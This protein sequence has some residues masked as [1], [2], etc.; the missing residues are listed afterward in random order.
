M[1][2]DD[3][4]LELLLDAEEGSSDGGQVTEHVEDCVRCQAR[5]LH[6]AADTEEWSETKHWLA[7]DSVENA[8]SEDV[9][10]DHN[11]R[12]WQRGRSAKAMAW[13]D[14]MAKSLL[15][16]PSHPEMLGRIGRYDVERLIGSGGMGLVFKAYDI[17][18]NRPV[19]VKL[20]APYLAEN[21]SARSRFAREARAAA[22]VVDE[23][24]VAIHNVESGEDPQQ[25]PFLVMK[26][27]AGGSL[28]QRLDRDG[29]LDV[30]EVL[31]IGMQTAKGLAA[32]HA[33]GLIHRD[34]KP[35]NILLDEGVD[36]ALLTDFGLARA[37]NDACLT[38]SGFHPGTPHYM[39]PE[40]VRGEAIDGRSD[41]FG[42][43]CVLYAMC[44]GHPPFRA[45]TSYAV[46]RRITDDTARRIR[47]LNP[48][49][50]LWLEQIVMK[51]L[52]KSRE[53]RFDS[54]E[55]VAELLEGC[56][57]HVQHPT[58]APLPESVEQ[59][60]QGRSKTQSD[61]SGRKWLRQ[62][63]ILGFAAFAMIFAGV[64]IVLET[65][66]GTLTIES[67]AD[68][69]PIRIMQ[70]GDVVKEFTVTKG[71]ESVR[72][73]AGQYVI[74]IDGQFAD[75]TVSDH[76][77][78]LRR[79][80]TQVVTLRRTQ[81]SNSE[82][83]LP[84]PL[85]RFRF[86]SELRGEWRISNATSDEHISQSYVDRIAVIQADTL[87]LSTSKAS[88]TY[89]LSFV[90]L[91]D[92]SVA[93]DL[94]VLLPGSKLDSNLTFHCL[95]Q[96][97]KDHLTLVRPQNQ[98]S[99]RPRSI[100]KPNYLETVFTL[101]REPPQSGAEIAEI[102][103]SE[104][105]SLEHW[106]FNKTKLP[107]DGA[108]LL[109]EALN[110]S[111]AMA[112]MTG[113][114]NYVL[115]I[116]QAPPSE[117]QIESRTEGTRAVLTTVIDELKVKISQSPDAQS[118]Q[119]TLNGYE[120][121]LENIEVTTRKG[122][123][124]NSMRKF[125]YHC[126]VGHDAKYFEF[127]RV[128]TAESPTQESSKLLVSRFTPGVTKASIQ[129]DSS[130]RMAIVS[131]HGVSAGGQD[132]MNLGRIDGSLA[133]AFKDTTA[134]NASWFEAR[135]L[136]DGDNRET[137]EITSRVAIGRLAGIRVRVIPSMGYVTPLVQELGKDGSVIREWKSGPYFRAKNSDLWFPETVT[138]QNNLVEKQI[139]VYTF[140]RDKVTLGENAAPAKLSML[141]LKG[142]RL[143]DAR[144]ANDTI[145]YA[146]EA[147]VELSL[148]ALEHL[149][150]ALKVK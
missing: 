135:K 6:L 56:L 8:A 149:E 125:A 73:A 7:L 143:M 89:L 58:T 55:Q 100:L 111:E 35:S 91:L 110:Q 80:E 82:C 37:E 138:F 60:S 96:I 115:S 127:E 129:F 22:A 59:L 20:L 78:S 47:E 57:A 50:P 84:S 119:S 34:I 49:I 137:Y 136:D 21:G 124:D 68:D 112:K 19:A 117:Q 40:Q 41:L 120:T 27:I 81:L 72:I 131:S 98:R 147:D 64:L 86:P 74:D 77:V 145:N 104:L 9:S 95:L 93:V 3:Q 150:I 97:S 123:L 107:V 122:M 17:E 18:L 108:Q 42:L 24:V 87:L 43:G 133:L 99:P 88:N 148:D 142:Q 12:P 31:R 92:D 106:T 101:V 130:D 67:D 15:S 114:F 65:N 118:L 38:R 11:A 1:K 53:D 128:V 51:L 85:T 36:R 113:E 16:P 103:P 29:P 62:L 79:G 4:S 69:V 2:C 45:E 109:K 66:K 146:I 23:H 126:I 76:V 132:P 144:E 141:L 52:S 46:L 33:Q 30:C 140:D 94:T 63:F 121:A 13:T 105:K 26:Y 14:A 116:A 139:Q 28:Q 75:I 10:L 44:T 71:A 83:D 48:N 61:G 54:A 70:G 39:S 25:P 90:E 102:K 134:L 32:A 5:L